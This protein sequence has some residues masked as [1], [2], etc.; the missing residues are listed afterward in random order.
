[1]YLS[2]LCSWSS[3]IRRNILKLSND[4]LLYPFISSHAFSENY[5]NLFPSNSESRSSV[6]Q[7]SKNGLSYVSS[8][9]EQYYVLYLNGKADWN[10]RNWKHYLTTW[11][12]F[13][14][15]CPSYISKCNDIGCRLIIKCCPNESQSQLVFI[16]GFRLNAW[17]K[18]LGYHRLRIFKRF[19]LQNKTHH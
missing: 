1:M 9:I 12:L 16:I 13:L 4:C 2:L 14:L 11:V 7:S 17:N 6:S 3:F 8:P 5:Y 10:D 19:V 15:F 18:V